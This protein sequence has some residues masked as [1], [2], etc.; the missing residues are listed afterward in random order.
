ME[1][2]HHPL[3][4]GKKWSHYFWEFLMLFLAVFL[5]FLAENKREHI[6][7][8]NRAKQYARSL[9]EDLKKDVAEI[10]AMSHESIQVLKAFDSIKA[11]IHSGIKDN[12]VRGS[13]YYQSRIGSIVPIVTWNKATL[14]Q[15]IQSGNMRYFTNAELTKKISNYYANTDEITAQ[16]ET[17]R[18]FRE[19]S[20]W[21]N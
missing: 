2:H 14:N 7:E 18:K 6:I 10:K 17:D 8:S 15:I 3:T 5:G 12:K 19:K 13:F 1:V 9:V 21:V 11:T 20:V 4:L 16:H